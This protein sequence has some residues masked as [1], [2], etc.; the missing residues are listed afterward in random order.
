MNVLFF[1]L[2]LTVYFGIHGFLYFS[3]LYFFPVTDQLQTLILIIYIA[4]SLSFIISLILSRFT[5][6][7]I[8]K[9]L[10]VVSAFWMGL[11]VFLFLISIPA[12]A[13]V[14]IIPSAKF[15]IGLTAFIL[16]LVISIYGV[17]GGLHSVVKNI[18]VKIKNLPTAWQGKTVAH[19]SDLHLGDINSV[20][21]ARRIV[22]Q[23]NKI[24]PKAV[25]ITGD[26]FDGIGSDF[27]LYLE[28]LNKLECQNIYYIFGNHE[29]YLGKEKLKQAFKD[30]KIKIL[31]NQLVELEDLQIIG[32]TYPKYNFNFDNYQPDKT[33]ILLNHEPVGLTTEKID[34]SSLE[35]RSYFSPNTDFSLQKE[36]K[37]NLQLSG[38]THQ[39]QF[40]PFD[41]LT[42][43]I[44]KGYHYGLFT[45]GDFNLYVSSGAGTWG[46]P[47]RIAS[48]SEIVAITL[49]MV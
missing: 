43:K 15:I 16:S 46:P 5:D 36:K 12:W 17:Y 25:F 47:F 40:F 7:F 29:I 34:K 28:T 22:K 3:T 11:A 8:V 1:I 32:L 33:V 42:Q 41:Y 44:F 49:K 39:G 4:L 27:S 9:A 13:L 45:E 20:V 30:S 6:F 26:L 14:L 38:H 35:W 24:N 18:E 48:K 31:D 19:I 23:I 2:S 37:I 10:Y 21:Y